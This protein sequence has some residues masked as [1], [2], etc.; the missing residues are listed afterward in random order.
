MVDR[1]VQAIIGVLLP[2][3]LVAIEKGIRVEFIISLLLT[4]F[5]FW[6]GGIIYSFYAVGLQDCV[7]N[8]LSALLP[9]L[10]VYLHKGLKAEFW[11]SIILT[12]LFWIPGMIYAY[13]L[14]LGTK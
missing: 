13:Y 11:I 12:I 6:I 8:I 1:L 5:L 14:V 3:L 7:K 10:A 2:P 9:P 4:I